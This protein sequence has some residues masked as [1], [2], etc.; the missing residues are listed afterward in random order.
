LRA[1][2]VINAE[3]TSR[4]P[5]AIPLAPSSFSQE[6]FQ[7]SPQH[8]PIRSHDYQQTALVAT[9]QVARP[10]SDTAWERFTSEGPLA[11][12][13]LGNDQFALVWCCRPETAQARAALPPHEFLLALQQVFGNRMGAFTH[14]SDRAAFA[15]SRHAVTELIRNIG[16]GGGEADSKNGRIAVIGNAAQTLHP[17][18]GQGLNL[19]LRDAHLLVDALGAYGATPDAL[20]V[21]AKNRTVDR[22]LAIAFTDML[23]RI[24][25]IDSAPLGVL[26]GSA[27]AALDC[28][29]AIK[30]RLSRQMMFGWRN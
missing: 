6:L 3:G 27:L 16:R 18:A 13:P 9:V 30:H 23:A 11:L 26:R 17:V 2:I 25:T 5:S 20:R 28:M 21:Y 15:L 19:G 14:V 29:P 7:H 1:R 4:V 8:S 22:H 10:H 24:F 12:L